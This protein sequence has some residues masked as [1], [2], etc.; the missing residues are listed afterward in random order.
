MGVV[1]II[2]LIFFP[3]LKNDNQTSNIFYF[4]GGIIFIM[5]VYRT[6]ND[7][8]SFLIYLFEQKDKQIDANQKAIKLMNRECNQ[9]QDKIFA[10]ENMPQLT[11]DNVQL[12]LAQQFLKKRSINPRCEETFKLLQQQP[13]VVSHAELNGVIELLKIGEFMSFYNENKE[14]GHP[15]F[16]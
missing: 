3:I 5:L 13:L 16:Q 7:S 4:L 6:Q 1:I 2:I 8:N 12:E 11:I 10:L 15:D 14:K 9:L